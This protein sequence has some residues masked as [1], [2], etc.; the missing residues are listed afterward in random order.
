MHNILVQSSQ[1][2]FAE[3][4]IEFANNFALL[5]DGAIHDINSTVYNL[6]QGV[7]HLLTC[8]MFHQCCSLTVVPSV[9]FT[10]SSA[11]SVVH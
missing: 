5:F 6:H 8:W 7:L 3:H 11:I 9:L 10:N 2:A 1:A 4:A